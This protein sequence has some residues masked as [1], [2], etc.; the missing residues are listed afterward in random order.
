MEKIIRTSYTGDTYIYDRIYELLHE[1]KSN[2]RD[3]TKRKRRN[4]G[5]KIEKMAERGWKKKHQK[6]SRTQKPVNI[7]SD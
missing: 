1:S 6:V 2:L 4:T 7:G 3:I 5:A